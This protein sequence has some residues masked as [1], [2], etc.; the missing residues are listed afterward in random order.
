MFS[1][2]KVKRFLPDIGL[3]QNNHLKWHIRDCF[4]GDDSS[5]KRLFTTPLGKKYMY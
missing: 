3:I 5:H 1:S 2:S 4:R